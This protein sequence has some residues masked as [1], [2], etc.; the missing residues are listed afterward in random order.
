MKINHALLEAMFNDELG[1]NTLS[2]NS[3]DFTK[4]A[5]QFRD[6]FDGLFQGCFFSI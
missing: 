6:D 5:A 2:E 4:K 3:G 1:I